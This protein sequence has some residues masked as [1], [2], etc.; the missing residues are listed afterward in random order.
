MQENDPSHQAATP[1]HRAAS[2]S[3]LHHTAS[4]SS[5]NS[6][7]TRPDRRAPR[8]GGP[9]GHGGNGGMS[10]FELVRQEQRGK[11]RTSLRAA[12]ARPWRGSRSTGGGGASQG[13]GRRKVGLG[14]NPTT[15]ALYLSDPCAQLSDHDGRQRSGGWGGG[16]HAGLNWWL[17]HQ[18]LGLRPRQ[19]ESR[20][21]GRPSHLPWAMN[22]QLSRAELR[23]SWA[24]PLAAAGC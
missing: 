2:T 8:R 5:A 22:A 9:Q 19:G 15:L 24:G 23:I 18:L 3:V 11:G 6:A 17:G 16:N 10:C 20:A 7:R 21:A 14:F 4:A 13:R 1:R 12:K